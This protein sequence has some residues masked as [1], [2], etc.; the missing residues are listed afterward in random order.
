L[1]EGEKERIETVFEFS[2]KKRRH[3]SLRDT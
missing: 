1:P 2:K 3:S